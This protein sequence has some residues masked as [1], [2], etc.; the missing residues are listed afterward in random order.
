[1]KE[2]TASAPGKVTLFGEHAV[3]YGYPAIVT[4]IGKRVYVTAKVREDSAVR[5]VAKDLRTPGLIVTYRE[6]SVEV[7]TDHGRSLLAVA[8]LN[9]A[10][11]LTSRKIGKFR[12]VDLIVESEMPVGAGLGTSAAVSVATVAAYSKL[13]GTELSRDEIADLAWSVEREVQGL[14]SPMDTSIST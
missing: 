12:G 4:S 5:I 7:S 1:M 10:I 14:A 2:V 11:E 8:Y 3:V 9:K 13:L 6:G